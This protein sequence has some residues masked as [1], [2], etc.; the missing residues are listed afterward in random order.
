MAKAGLGTLEWLKRSGGR[1]A[2]R[3]RL[4]MMA[5]GVRA[6]VGARLARRGARKQGRTLRLREVAEVLPPDSAI[7]REAAALCAEESPPYLFHHC[8]RA[9]FWARLLDDGTR[10]F[11]DEV[12][13]TSLLLHDLGLTERYQKKVERAAC[14]T[15]AG[16]DAA[17]ALALRHG[18]TDTRARLAAQAISLHLNV[19][20][21][22]RHGREAQLVR[23]GSGGDVAGIGLGVLPA[24]Q[25]EAVVT[26]YPRL[27]LKREIIGI[28]SSEAAAHPDCRLAFLVKHLGFIRLVRRAPLFRE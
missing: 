8:L 6:T 4:T 3:E 26:R 22:D 11:D 24:D 17:A 1:I 5:Q 20:V 2:L 12:L 14:F 21:K 27:G 28:L 7:T 25:I 13:Y 9:Y 23:A 16:A 18:W 19:S 15:A 10:P